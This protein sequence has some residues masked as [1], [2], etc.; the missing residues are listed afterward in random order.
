[1]L[2]RK[3]YNSKPRTYVKAK[4]S[5]FAPRNRAPKVKGAIYQSRKE[6]KYVDIAA[7]GYA[8][9]TT[10]SVTLLSGI[11]TGDDNNTRDGR[12]VTI[13]SVQ[14]RGNIQPQDDTSGPNHAR[15]M[16]VWDNAPNGTIAT[17]ANIL[18]A[19]AATSFPL[20]NNSQRFTILYDHSFIQ[21]KVSTTATQTFASGQMTDPIKVYLKM[22]NVAQYN[23]TGA[24]IA[25]VQ[26]GALYLVTI[27]DQAA[28]AASDAYLA[29][30]VRFTDD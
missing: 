12:Q 9:D 23:G 13:K 6:L 1:M 19:S 16:L 8:C 27:G 28:T 11:A 15:V 29:T 10:G 24:T 17:I 26:N 4:R 5:L 21:G 25:S 18:T 14:L 3:Q 22:N 7:A 30:R 2:K 20:V